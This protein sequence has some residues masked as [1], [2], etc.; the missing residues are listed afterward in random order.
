MK[1]SPTEILELAAVC[2]AFFGIPGL[3]AVPLQWLCRRIDTRISNAVFLVLFPAPMLLEI[4]VLRVVEHRF[5][6]WPPPSFRY[7]LITTIHTPTMQALLWYQFLVSLGAYLLLRRRYTRKVRRSSPDAARTALKTWPDTFLKCA[8]PFG[9]LFSIYLYEY[10]GL[11]DAVRDGNVALAKRRLRFNLYGVGVQNGLYVPRDIESTE[12]PLVSLIPL[13]VKLGNEPMIRL[14][15]ENNDDKEAALGEAWLIK[16]KDFALM[17]VL[18]NK[19]A[20]IDGT[21]KARPICIAAEFD[22]PEVIQWLI[23]HG[24]NVNV[25][26]EEDER[27][28]DVAAAKNAPHAYDVLLDHNATHRNLCRILNAGR[29]DILLKLADTGY[30]FDSECGKGGPTFMEYAA[31]VGR[32]DMIGVVAAHGGD[33]NKAG[34]MTPLQAAVYTGNVEA[35]RTLIEL[36]A[37]VDTVDFNGVTLLHIAARDDNGPMVR[38]LCEHGADTRVGRKGPNAKEGERSEPL[39]WLEFKDGTRF[40]EECLICL[41]EHGADKEEALRRA[42]HAWNERAVRT[43][44]SMKPPRKAVDS[45][46]EFVKSTG[47]EGARVT[48]LSG[49]RDTL[50]E[51]RAA[52]RARILKVLLEAIDDDSFAKPSRVGSG[53]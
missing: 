48:R 49:V 35:A 44:L 15:V 7:F 25:Q 43:V 21:P 30:N 5:C 40:C 10:K 6:D 38:L 16:K 29:M 1:L 50:S 45:A 11:E 51:S 46:L 19:G 13:A 9:L 22:L 12:S 8:I 28:L 3:L 53:D 42:T 41:L 23:D 27:P 2:A 24:A 47:E 18:L 37:R 39:D 33:V 4:W 20:K 52:A 31:R 32:T 17:E 36:G 26:T 14:L 34:T